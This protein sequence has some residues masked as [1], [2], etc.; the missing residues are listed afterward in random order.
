MAVVKAA[1]FA[2]FVLGGEVAPADLKDAMCLT[3]I[4]HFEANGERWVGKKAVANVAITRSE[5]YRFPDDLC[6]VLHQPGQFSHVS[7]GRSLDDVVLTEPGDIESFHETL[8]LVAR[9]FKEGIDDV[10]EGADHFFNP[11]LSSPPWGRNPISMVQ[12]GNH[13]FVQVYP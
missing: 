8:A 9:S 2:L 4:V 13:R 12:I 11:S 5:L 6:G 3:E 10:T 1:A 7:A